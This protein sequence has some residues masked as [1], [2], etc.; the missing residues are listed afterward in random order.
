MIAERDYIEIPLGGKKFPGRVA[1]IDSEDAGLV[2]KA[3]WTAVVTDRNRD[4]GEEVRLVE[5]A[6]TNNREGLFDGFPCRPLLHRV[7]MGITD[8]RVQIDHVNRN[9]LDCRKS[10]LRIS[11]Q[12]ENV[13]N[14]RP[15]KDSTSKYKGVFWYSSA[16]KWRAV[17]VPSGKQM[18]LGTFSSE[19][20]AAITY[21]NAAMEVFGEF[22]YLNFP[23]RR[24]S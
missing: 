24:V 23:E 13:F 9:G 11:T 22:A 20:D 6:A 15:H 17:I 3:S 21:D 2:M 14:T 7:V 5:Y 10:N 16:R 1:V 19:I 18:H 4:R 12:Q 8:R